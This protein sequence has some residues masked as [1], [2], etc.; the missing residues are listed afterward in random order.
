MFVGID[1]T[2]CFLED[3]ASI[4]TGCL[5]RVCALNARPFAVW[6]ILGGRTRLCGMINKV[7]AAEDGGDDARAWSPQ[8]LRVTDEPSCF[9]KDGL[10]MNVAEEGIAP[11]AQP[12][13]FYRVYL[14][15]PRSQ[16]KRA[17]R[18]F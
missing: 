12:R 15:K 13:C 2:E 5:Q 8:L 9:H 7:K 11:H 17:S 10:R 6:D 14:A 3:R 16:P 4:S 18:C 1:C